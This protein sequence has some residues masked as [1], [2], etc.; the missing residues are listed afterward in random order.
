[1]WLRENKKSNIVVND[2]KGELAKKFFVPATYRG[3]E[4]VQF[5]LINPLN[6]IMFLIYVMCVSPHQ[7]NTRKKLKPVLLQCNP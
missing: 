7:L 1:M 4:V 2:P 3:Y 6:N 5:N